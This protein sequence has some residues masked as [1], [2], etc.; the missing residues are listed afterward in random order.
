MRLARGV[1]LVAPA[2]HIGLQLLAAFLLFLARRFGLRLALAPL[3]FELFIIAGIE[4]RLAACHVKDVARDSVQEIA[5]MADDDQARPVGLEKRLQPE[6]RFEI[7]M[8]GRLIE[9]QEIRLGEE[10]RGKRDTH[11]PATGEFIERSDLRLFGK[12]EAGENAGRPRRSAMGIDR[13]EPFMNLGNAVRVRCM[14]GFAQER[15]PLLGRREHGVERRGCAPRRF[16]G[17]IADTRAG[18][19]FDLPFVRLVHP[20]DQLEQ[21]RFACAVA[22]DE[23]QPG[24]RRDRNGGAVQNDVAAK[25]QRDG[26]ERKHAC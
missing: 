19:C 24:F 11:A 1:R 16:L 25:A 22:A 18:R 7:E 5:L 8:V 9:Q 26:I 4:R 23:A 6:R 14:L 13:V 17:Q 12:A 3:A 20:S 21:R 15:S 10:Q 2:I